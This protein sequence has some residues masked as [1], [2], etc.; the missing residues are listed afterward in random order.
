MLIDSDSLFALIERVHTGEVDLTDIKPIEEPKPEKPKEPGPRK[1]EPQ[2]PE[3]PPPAPEP[4]TPPPPKTDDN[5]KQEMA[6]LRN[7]INELKNLKNNVMSLADQLP[8]LIEQHATKAASQ[9]V[10]EAV[11]QIMATIGPTTGQPDT[12]SAGN[13]SGMPNS[14]TPNPASPNPPTHPS[15]GPG[16]DPSNISPTLIEKQ[17]EIELME[18][19]PKMSSMDKLLMAISNPGFAKLLGVMKAPEQQA[20]S[21]G[22]DQGVGSLVNAMQVLSKKKKMFTQQT[23]DTINA[24]KQIAVADKIATEAQIRREKGRLPEPPKPKAKKTKTE[25]E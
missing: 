19:L 8:S 5:I 17:L 16:I 24:F 2:K 13:L 12:V 25:E 11:Q 22:G 23:V 10:Q 6:Q 20:V 1:V 14:E 18:R 3:P 21:G 9:A 4:P 15:P 7:E